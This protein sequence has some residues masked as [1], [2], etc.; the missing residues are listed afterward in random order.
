MDKKMSE[1]LAEL[2]EKEGALTGE[3]VAER[4]RNSHMVN[5][6]TAIP[7]ILKDFVKYRYDKDYRGLSD[8]YRHAMVNC[9]AAQRGVKDAIRV[10]NLSGLKEFFDVHSGGNTPE[11][12]NEDMSA[13]LIGRYLGLKHPK[14]DCDELVQRY[15]K[16]T[17]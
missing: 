1:L 8:K 3:E 9:L 7:N 16:K 11:E 4:T 14:D 15:I 6:G 12:S 5:Y 13:N 10:H 17:Y 2:L